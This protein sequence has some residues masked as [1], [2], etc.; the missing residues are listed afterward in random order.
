LTIDDAL[1]AELKRQAFREGLPL[2]Q[3]IDRALRVG[4]RAMRAPPARRRYRATTY[5]M[6]APRVPSFD[7]ALEI[8]ATLE[9]EEIARRLAVRK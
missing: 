7:K 6:G 9:E 2:R 8:A 4:L 1:M 3:V 5:S